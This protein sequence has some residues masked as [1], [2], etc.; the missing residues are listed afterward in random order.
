MKTTVVYAANEAYAIPLAAS[1]TGLAESL[2]SRGDVVVIDTGITG[3]SRARLAA[4]LPRTWSVAFRRLP[5]A[6]TDA[7]PDPGR[8]SRAAYG[9]FFVHQLA[10]GADRVIYL[11]ADTLPVRSIQD[12]LEMDLGGAT[13]A[14]VRDDYIATF[15]SPFGPAERDP[16]LDPAR[17]YFNSGVLVIDPAAWRRQ[18]VAE[19]ATRWLQRF[20]P[21]TELVDQDALNVVLQGDWRELPPVWNVGWGWYEPGRCEGPF[22]TMP[23]IARI[24]H[25]T[26][27]DKPWSVPCTVPR[28]ACD[29]F[30]AALDR[31][32]WSGWRPHG[33][34]G[35]AADAS[36]PGDANA[37]ARPGREAE[38]VE[39]GDGRVGM[40]RLVAD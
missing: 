16:G 32:P 12:L 2:G 1:L 24:L 15:G 25:Y 34:G 28:W 3:R 22:E 18:R 11:D 19:R 23:Q 20:G 31:T 35:R 5:Y 10:A 38:T 14:A 27:E 29:P 39:V 13:A 8:F 21:G 33:R 17:P 7:L 6:W 40:H 30:F 9:R 26:T 4:C 36:A 37:S